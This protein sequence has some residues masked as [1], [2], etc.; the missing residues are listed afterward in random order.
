MGK[1][2]NNVVTKG[3]TGKISDDIV[4]RQSGGEIIIAK[5]PKKTTKPLHVKK[6]A[7]QKAFKKAT[8]YGNSVMLDTAVKAKY[9]AVARGMQSAYNLAVRDASK[10][11]EVNS[12]DASQYKGQPGNI[13]KIDAQDDFQVIAVKLSIHAA[14]GT[15]IEEGEAV[16]PPLQMDWEYTV[17]MVNNALAG[18]KITATAID[19]PKNQHSLEITL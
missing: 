7:I 13:I 12:I 14:D 3:F 19:L 17:T 8:L 10:P 1:N 15:L 11:P 5:V 6:K 18:S 9:Q 16:L 4:F 2:K